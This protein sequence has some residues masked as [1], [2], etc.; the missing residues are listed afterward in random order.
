MGQLGYLQFAK[1][2]VL[3]SSFGSDVLAGRVSEPERSH[4][5]P[6]CTHGLQRNEGDYLEAIREQDEIPQ[7]AV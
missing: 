2:G 4:V 1:R 3:G 7:C 6:L 5:D